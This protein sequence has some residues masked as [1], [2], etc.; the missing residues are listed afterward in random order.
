MSECQ[1]CFEGAEQL[2]QRVMPF[3]RLKQ[4]QGGCGMTLANKLPLGGSSDDRAAV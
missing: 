4:Q 2:P 1:V 3:V